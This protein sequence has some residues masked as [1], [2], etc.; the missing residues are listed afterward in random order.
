M[1]FHM[2]RMI[3]A[4]IGVYRDKNFISLKWLKML[5]NCKGP[6]HSARNLSM[7]RN[8]YSFKRHEIGGS[9]TYSIECCSLIIPLYR[10]QE[11]VLKVLLAKEVNY[12]KE[13]S[14]QL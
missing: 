14:R 4:Y 6:I 13:A 12:F 7:Y 3:L 1:I 2:E 5:L 8:L 9:H 11:K 10:N